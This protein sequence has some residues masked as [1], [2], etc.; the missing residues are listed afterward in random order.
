MLQKQRQTGFQSEIEKDVLIA[1]RKFHCNTLV[2]KGNLHGLAVALWSFST[3][4]ESLG[5]TYK[6]VEVG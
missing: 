4:L 2:F 1:S 3:N 5:S 6:L